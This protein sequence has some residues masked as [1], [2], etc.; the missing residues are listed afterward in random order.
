LPVR[1][2]SGTCSV[3]PGSGGAMPLKARGER[4]GCTD[5]LVLPV[6]RLQPRPD[7]A[8]RRRV[9]GIGPGARAVDV[10]DGL[11][12]LARGGG[13]RWWHGRDPTAVGTAGRRLATA[14]QPR[15]V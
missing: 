10:R 11:G 4:R 15:R 14:Q 8:R 13:R 9:G 12:P 1:T 7:R 3:W 5:A 2:H 6:E